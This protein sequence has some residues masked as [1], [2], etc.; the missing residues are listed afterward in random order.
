MLNFKYEIL[1]NW[2]RGLAILLIRMSKKVSFHGRRTTEPLG[3]KNP[4]NLIKMG[5]KIYQKLRES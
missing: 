3:C 1:S 4:I 2:Q 5:E